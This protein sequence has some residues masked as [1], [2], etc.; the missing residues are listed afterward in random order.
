MDDSETVG[1]RVLKSRILR[2]N[3]VGCLQVFSLSIYIFVLHFLF[4]VVFGWYLTFYMSDYK[5]LII[6]TQH[7][8]LNMIKPQT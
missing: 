3:V 7:M 4:H 5:P 6:E 1:I 8:V 2:V